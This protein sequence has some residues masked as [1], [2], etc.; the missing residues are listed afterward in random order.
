MIDWQTLDDA[1][2]S[3]NESGKFILV[4]FFSPT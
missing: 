3:A 2:A 4:D 1:T